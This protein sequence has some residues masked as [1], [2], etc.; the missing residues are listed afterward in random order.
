[1]LR[2]ESYRARRVCS[3]RAATQANI[4]KTREMHNADNSLI[5]RYFEDS[6]KLWQNVVLL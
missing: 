5:C 6:R 4:P 1:M 3:N 2:F